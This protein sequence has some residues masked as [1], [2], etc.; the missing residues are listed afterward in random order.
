MDQFSPLHVAA[1]RWTPSM[2]GVQ[3]WTYPIDITKIKYLYYFIFKATYI[4]LLSRFLTNPKFG[5]CYH[6]GNFVKLDE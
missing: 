3:F 5:I 2:I 1:L 4:I 6:M